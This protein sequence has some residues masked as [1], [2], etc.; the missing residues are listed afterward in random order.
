MPPEDLGELLEVRL[1]GREEWVAL[2]EGNH[3]L[4][5]RLPIPHDE[6]QGSIAL[7]TEKLP[8]PST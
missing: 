4:E 1:L 8:S 5:E 3:A 7:E 2:E 6:H